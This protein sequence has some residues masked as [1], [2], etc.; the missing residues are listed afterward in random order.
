[1]ESSRLVNKLNSGFGSK[2]KSRKSKTKKSGKKFERTSKRRKSIKKS[3]KH[4]ST[5]VDMDEHL[6]P[7]E[8]FQGPVIEE[9]VSVESDS[10]KPTFDSFKPTFD[11]FKEQPEFDIRTNA[12]D[13]DKVVRVLTRLYSKDLDS[14]VSKIV[15]NITKEVNMER[16]TENEVSNLVK[17]ELIKSIKQL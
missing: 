10:F 4:V 2:R 9:K 3:K 12:S 5:P 7:Q 1:M 13:S 14:Y 16:R 6:N 15:K 17:K 8:F 11:S